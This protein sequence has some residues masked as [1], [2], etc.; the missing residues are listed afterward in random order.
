LGTGI[1]WA[2][3][4]LLYTAAAGAI[5]GFLP[6][7]GMPEEIVAKGGLPIATPDG[8]TIAY[9][10]GD[11]AA[12]DNGLWKADGDGRHAVLLV[13]GVSLPSAFTSD[14]RHV[15]FLS[16]RSG[17]Q[18]PWLVSLDGSEPVQVVNLV[19]GLGSGD[20]S[21]DGKSILLNSA[22]DQNR[23][24][25]IMCDLPVCTSRRTLPGAGRRFRN[26]G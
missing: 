17:V 23:T 16:Q 12:P 20:V 6:G 4:R 25:I 2:G 10:G 18:S 13:P 19:A 15:I 22:D 24:A 3:D 5:M 11:L 14:G 21:P 8:Q 9:F 7:R 1:T 26:A